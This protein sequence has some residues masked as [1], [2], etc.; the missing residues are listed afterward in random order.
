MCRVVPALRAEVKK[1]RGQRPFF[2][3]Y[4]IYKMAPS[5]LLA[6]GLTTLATR[7]AR[8]FRRELMGIAALVCRLAAFA[9]NFTLSFGVHGGKSAFGFSG[10]L[11]CACARPFAA[12]FAACHF[13]ISLVSVRR[14][15]LLFTQAAA[16]G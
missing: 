14:E 10:L 3:P 16:H 12:W 2:M 15:I 9:G 11:A 6:A 7:L 5:A 13:N 8:F 4:K 1:G